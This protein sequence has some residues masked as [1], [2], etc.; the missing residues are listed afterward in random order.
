MSPIIIIKS[1]TTAI[2][3]SIVK[4][5]FS[6][7]SASTR[8]L[9]PTSTTGLYSG[10]DAPN[11]GY[12]IYQIG[13][14]NG[15]T[16]RVATNSTE[17]NTI[18]I[19]AGA[20]GTTLNDRIAWATNTNSIFINSGN[21]TASVQKIIAGGTFTAFDGIL[22]YNRLIR[23]TS[24]GSIDST[25]NIGTG[26]DSAVTTTSIQ[27]DGKVL[28]GGAFTLFTGSSQNF[29]IRLNS[30]GSKDTT[31]NIGTGFDTTVQSISIQSDGKIIVGGAFSTFTGSSQNFLIRLN[32]DGS[33]DTTFNIGTGFAPIAVATT[34][35]QSDGKV[36]VGGFFTTFSGGSQN[37]FIRLNT[38]GS[39]DTTFNIGTGFN[40][41]V[42]SASIQS[43]G[44]IIAGGFFSTFTGSTQ[45]RLIRLNSDG[46][47]DTTFNIGTGF[48]GV[49]RAISIQSDGKII[50][51]G[52][53]TTF[54]GSPQNRLIRLNSDGSKDTTFNI[55]DGFG[56]TVRS[57]SIQSDG[58]IMVGGDFFNYQ[59]LAQNALIRLNSDGSK[60]S[61]FDITSGGPN[62]FV[63]SVSIQ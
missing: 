42:E 28:A 20:T 23:L 12:T 30:N 55:G 35:I 29:L 6:Y 51:G 27:S 56:D 48:N 34:S 2:P 3:G 1:G 52:G 24:D 47:R 40:D 32:S 26:F 58:K 17:L 60:D 44:K 25:F 22:G 62:D 11:D 39:K 14:P 63:Y 54:T 21:T 46:S 13:G 43:D 49:V 36:L 19:S 45:N 31:F 4:G 7:F 59:G 61:T 33:K 53:F 5:S 38:N 16:I 9:G 57:I 15:F 41:S 10:I 8:D 50:A 37:Y 18:L